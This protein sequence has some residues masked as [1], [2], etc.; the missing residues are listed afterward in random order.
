MTK[1]MKIGYMAQT[2]TNGSTTGRVASRQH[3]FLNSAATTYAYSQGYNSLSAA[4]SDPIAENIFGNAGYAIKG[5]DSAVPY[6]NIANEQAHGCGVE[7][8][9]DSF[10]TINSIA[11]C[12]TFYW[13]RGLNDYGNRVANDSNWGRVA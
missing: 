4:I 2:I 9:E 1:N 7:T 5:I 3:L 11:A 10:N 6:L 12:A 13:A 8:R